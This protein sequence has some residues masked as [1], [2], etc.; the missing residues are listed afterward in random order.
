MS[1]FFPERNV[2]VSFIIGTRHQ[3]MPERIFNKRLNDHRREVAIQ[4]GL[5]VDLQIELKS[6]IETQT[7]KFQVQFQGLNFVVNSDHILS[8][9]IQDHTQQFGKFSDVIRSTFHFIFQNKQ[10][11]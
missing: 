10:T 7:L 9:V 6:L 1:A 2:N 8:R 4:N 3:S 5:S 11:N